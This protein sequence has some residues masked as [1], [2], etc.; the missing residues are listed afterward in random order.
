VNKA[1]E[2]I[3]LI[4]GLSAAAHVGEDG[5]LT[6]WCANIAISAESLGFVAET[7]RGLIDSLGAEQFPAR[8]GTAFFGER[9]LIFRRTR[10]GLFMAYL[11]AP[12]DD[13]VLAWLFEKIE[14]LLAAEGV[15]LA[16]TEAE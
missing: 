10:P 6:G 15:A 11:D 1:F 9:T 13:G 16:A 8:I 4:P 2:E 12:A 5:H 14:P 3:A 7:C